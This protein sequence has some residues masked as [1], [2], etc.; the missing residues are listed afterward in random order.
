MDVSEGKFSLHSRHFKAAEAFSTAKSVRTADFSICTHVEVTV[1]N[2]DGEVV[3]CWEVSTRER[4]H[5]TGDGVQHKGK[6]V[7]RASPYL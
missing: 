1:A 7:D 4:A 2:R 3:P 5:R 6:P